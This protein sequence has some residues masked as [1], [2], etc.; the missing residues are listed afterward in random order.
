MDVLGSLPSFWSWIF[1]SNVKHLAEILSQAMR[2]STL[3]ASSVR[4]N[5]SLN[6]C[7]IISSGELLLFRLSTS[8]DR[9]S[10]QLFVNASIEFKNLQD[11]FTSKTLCQMCSMTFLPQ[12]F[13]SS[14]KR[15]C[16]FSLPSNDA[17]P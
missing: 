1:D 8:N 11:L 7:G 13:S 14:E 2:G 16:L 9:N 3:D 6:C 4:W 10:K 15:G 12:E 17:V 5:V